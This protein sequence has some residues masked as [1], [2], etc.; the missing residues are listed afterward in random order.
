MEQR[1]R[2][3]A[4][5]KRMRRRQRTRRLRLG[6]LGLLALF[7]F[8]TTRGE[9]EKI[10]VIEEQVLA[11]GN[12][13]VAVSSQSSGEAKTEI[14]Q[15][16]SARNYAPNTPKDIEIEE[17][18]V[19][20]EDLSGTYPEFSQIL[21]SKEQYSEKLLIALANNPEMYQFVANYPAHKGSGKTELTKEEKQKSWPLLLQWDE[22]WGYQSYGDSMIGLAGC[23]PTCL[24]MAV[25]G[26]TG[27]DTCT[28]DVVADYCM[29]QGYYV[30]GVGTS[31][32]FLTQGAKKFGITAE[33]TSMSEEVMKRCLDQGQALICSMYP[34]DFTAN[35]HFILIYGYDRNGFYVNDPNCIQRS[36]TVWSYRTLSGQMRNMWALKV[37]GQT[38]RAVYQTTTDKA[39]TYQGL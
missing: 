33:V 4:R 38:G 36:E 7:L 29:K 39:V 1:T 23:G 13:Y 16:E 26:L 17:A 19:I 24:S 32:D 9:K 18:L 31:W 15:I 28:P 30:D 20:L 37:S 11:K 22:R 6:I 27:D 3:R 25:Q 14:S 34:G 12:D 21:T 2:S 35:G 8:F 5:K 10:A